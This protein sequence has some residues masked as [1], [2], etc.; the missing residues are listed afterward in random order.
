MKSIN[1]VELPNAHT[2]SG[3]SWISG[4]QRSRNFRVVKMVLVYFGFFLFSPANVHSECGG[5]PPRVYLHLLLRHLSRLNRYEKRKKIKVWLEHP[6]AVILP[7]TTSRFSCCCCC[8][9]RCVSPSFRRAILLRC[10]H[11]RICWLSIA[12]PS[13]GLWRKCLVFG[14][15]KSRFNWKMMGSHR[16]QSLSRFPIVYSDAIR[17]RPFDSDM[18]QWQQQKNEKQ[19]EK[20]SAKVKI[21]WAVI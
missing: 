3:V 21:D 15:G 18:F 17:L 11:K 20:T 6:P 13:V 4:G 7:I 16:V 14:R 9:I 2:H 19:R 8:G 10:G 12:P 5:W 1:R